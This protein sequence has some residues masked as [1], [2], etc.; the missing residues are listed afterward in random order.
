MS[1]QLPYRYSCWTLVGDWHHGHVI[2]AANVDT[3]PC[4]PPRHQAVVMVD[5][6]WGEHEWMLYPQPYRH[7][8]PYLAWLQLPLK[9]T[10]TDIL[11]SPIHKKMWQAHSSKLNIHTVNPRVF[12]ELRD[13]LNNVKAAVL[14]PFHEI[15]ADTCFSHIQPPK[16][17]YA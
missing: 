12:S 7:E 5:G 10:T 8:S 15:I 9:N 6:L 1:N 17:A 4:P 16:T 13:K 11:S 3:I 14:N 2:L